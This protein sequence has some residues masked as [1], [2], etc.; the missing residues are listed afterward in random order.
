M[1][2]KHQTANKIAAPK[3]KLKRVLTPKELARVKAIVITNF[4]T[5]NRLSSDMVESEYGDVIGT[6]RWT[7]N[8]DLNM[9]KYSY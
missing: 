9:I 6:D 2:K 8:Q 1:K 7:F 5:R 3:N 4:N